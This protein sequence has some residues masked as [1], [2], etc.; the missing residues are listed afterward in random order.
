M[1]LDCDACLARIEDRPRYCRSKVGLSDVNG[2]AY[3]VLINS[4]TKTKLKIENV[5]RLHNSTI[6]FQDPDLILMIKN[7]DQVMLKLLF[8]QLKKLVKGEKLHKLP[9]FDK[10]KN[11]KPKITVLNQIGNDFD[12]NVFKNS[13]LN[14][15]TIEK[16]NLI[17]PRQIWNLNYLTEL[18]LVNC[19][20]DCLP[21]R[22]TKLG[23]TLKL[24]NLSNNKI[25]KIDKLFFAKMPHLV[26][27]NLS[28]NQIK[29]IHLD[30][31]L[32]RNLVTIDLSDN[33]LTNL[34][35]TLIYLRKLTELNLSDNRL[36]FFSINVWSSI[37]RLRLNKLDISNNHSYSDPE[38]RAKENE[39]FKDFVVPTLKQLASGSVVRKPQL[40]CNL[41]DFLPS[42]LNDEIEK[43]ADLCSNCK[44]P[45]SSSNFFTKVDRIPLYE[46]ANGA[47]HQNQFVPL[48]RNMCPVC[49]FNT[50]FKT[51]LR[52]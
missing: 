28:K 33:Q 15:L 25:I 46:L 44:K 40:F 14:K 6:V 22:L 52:I 51:S 16:A 41:N 13:L 30:I 45:F 9:E 37:A 50:K 5:K 19:D 31:V 1:I 21:E 43:E 27:L 48:S 34:P 2:Q 47:L 26:Y 12:C 23:K 38:Q 3:V 17:L 4:K 42:F 20:L 8:A 24:L 10:I 36:Q 39:K 11:E 29:L 49:K 35:F 7:A 18:S 32:S